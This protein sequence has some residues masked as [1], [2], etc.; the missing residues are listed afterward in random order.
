MLNIDNLLISFDR[1]L[2]VV[3]GQASASR[4]NPGDAKAE[5]VL[6]ERERQHSAGLMRVNHVGEIC[7]QALY[8]SQ[9][10]FTQTTAIQEQ[11]LQSA[12]EEQDHLAWTAERLRELNS[13]ISL[14]SPI[15][16][17][18]AYACGTIAAKC[19]DAA[20]LG[21]VVETEKQ[22]EAHLASHLQQLPAQDAKSRA[23]VEQMRMDE[24]AHGAAADALGASKLPLPVQ[25]AMQGMAKVM[26]TTAY[27]I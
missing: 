17:I 24:V 1:A 13:R 23:I 5:I 11:F 18:G 19:G 7:A 2:R 6:E 8:D 25:I 10:Q 16:Y 12:M 27:Y 9:R 14:L 26:T 3:S 15:W 22:V 4:P 21:F 20:S